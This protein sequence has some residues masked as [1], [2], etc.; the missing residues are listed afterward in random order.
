VVGAIEKRFALSWFQRL[1]YRY[2]IIP[3]AV[4]SLTKQAKAYG[5]QKTRPTQGRGRT[6]TFNPTKFN[7][8]QMPEDRTIGTVDLPAIW[9]QR[10]RVGLWLHWDGNN[11]AIRERNYAAAMAVGATA[12]SVIPTNF[13]RTTDFVLGLA[14]P[15]F[16]FDIDARK[17]ERGAQIF[18]VNCAACHAFGS[19]KIG[20]VTPIDVIGTD[21]HRLDSFTQALVTRF[22][23]VNEPPFVFDAYRK[24]HGYSNLPIDGIWMRGPYLHNG[25]V[26][27]LWDLLQP[28]DKRPK[29]FYI[30]YRV[31]DPIRVGFVSQGPAAKAAG[32]L[33][34]TSI[35]GNGNTGHTYGVALSD[36]DK[37][38]LIEYL[39]T[40]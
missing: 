18:Q 10:A 28:P 7:V 8:F 39:K 36:E 9:N 2:L 34:D 14:P 24:T 22:H 26:P 37:L 16:P 3:T 17:A 6:D 11:N 15:R 19:K 13:Q 4:Q 21:R 30:G 31:L 33:L 20:Q 1:V 25:S 35:P 29:T 40:L 23:S 32:F 38:A 12:K 27:T 5:W